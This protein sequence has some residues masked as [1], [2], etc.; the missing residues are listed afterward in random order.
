MARIKKV[1]EYLVQQG[2]EALIVEAPVDLYY[3]TGLHF[4][5]G[6]LLVEREKASLF[7]DGRYTE[8]AKTSGLPVEPLES[9]SKIHFKEG[10]IAFDSASTTYSTYLE[11]LAIFDTKLV[12]VSA[13]VKTLR[14]IKEKEEIALLKKAA[15]LGSRGYDF[16]LTLLEEG[17]TEET[18]S[19]ELEIFW[20]KQGGGGVSFEPIIAFGANTS[21]PHYRA[22][23]AKLKQGD[24]VLIDIGVMREHYAS[25]MTRV[26]FFGEPNTQLKTIYGVVKEAFLAATALCKK[27]TLLADLD[28]AARQLIEKAGYGEFFSHS[29]GH[30]VG[31]EVHE[32]PLVRK[33]SSM[34]IEVGMVFTIEPGIYLPGIGGVRLEDTVVITRDGYESLTNRPFL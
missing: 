3:L 16:V 18:V 26:V 24:P 4:S 27:G 17:I 1:Q 13:P 21:K 30:G 6:K 32:L 23:K 31:L 19:R 10:N 5:A 2:L 15:E 9:F 14:S 28:N 22:G 25:D 33:T 12:A 8:V 29:L 7:V 11:L 34:P 20:K